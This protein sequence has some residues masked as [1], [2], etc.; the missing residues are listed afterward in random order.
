MAID[1]KEDNDQLLP[2]LKNKPPS[3]FAYKELSRAKFETVGHELF[4]IDQTFQ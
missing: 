2:I 4:M 1:A 3:V